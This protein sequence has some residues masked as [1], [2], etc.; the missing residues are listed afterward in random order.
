MLAEVESMARNLEAFSA[1]LPAMGLELEAEGT[2][3][4]AAMLR[5][6]WQQ[7]M[8]KDKEIVALHKHIDLLSLD[9]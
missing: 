3:R 4:A 2:K 6:M 7:I 5:S 9:L 1:R 8:E